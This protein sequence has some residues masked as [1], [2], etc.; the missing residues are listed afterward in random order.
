MKKS[1][2]KLSRIIV[3]DFLKNSR[4]CIETIVEELRIFQKKNDRE[5]QL[6]RIKDEKAETVTLNRD[7]FF[8]RSSVEYSNPQLTVEEV[9]GIIAARL[10]EVC[11]N[12]F[13]DY[14][15][16]KADNGD[17]SAI[18]ELLEKPPQGKITPFLLNT[19][20]VEPDRYSMNPLKESIVKSGQ[21]AFPS[22]SVKTER[23]RIDREF[24]KKYNGKLISKFEAEL[25]ERH[26]S[27]CNNSYMNMVDAVKAE[28]L[29]ILSKSFGIDLSLPILRMPLT[30][31]KKENTGDL[32][33]YIIRNVH[34]DYDSIEHIY[35]CMGR[36]M[37]NRTT[38]LT[39]PHSEKGFGSKRAARGK[40][41]FKDTRLDS[42]RT[43]Y[44][45]TQLYP[46]AIDPN[47]VSIAECNDQFIVEGS[48]LVNYDFQ[49]TPSS[50]Q[51][52]LYSLGSPEDATLWHGIGTFASSQLVKSYVS[53]RLE[54]TRNL[55]GD[56]FGKY[57]VTLKMPP[58]F[59]LKPESMWVHPIY[60]NIDA[61]MGCVENL[62]DLANM[63]M[64]L[65]CL[66]AYEYRRKI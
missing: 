11:G 12:Y 59:N 48:N 43:V 13:F 7:H 45:T 33:H 27:K 65:E 52:V 35:N 53:V 16:K 38:L 66:L 2:S 60:R 37:K 28:H 62:E 26:L 50:P 30:V 25:V 64:K 15:I 9:Q 42:V 3:E 1:L 21:S 47:D 44:E 6:L 20:D 55:L 10:L 4:L 8:L 40:I 46:N 32:L 63:G 22:A 14:R 31:L 41:Y 17:V 58:Q 34:K 18:C 56:D 51:F 49:Q 61:S 5:I 54:P 36:S 29:M 24:M 23:L 57:D 19:D 39:V